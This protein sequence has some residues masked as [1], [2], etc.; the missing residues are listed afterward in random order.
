M[1]LLKLLFRLH[2]A[3]C[4]TLH[5]TAARDTAIQCLKSDDNDMSMVNIQVGKDILQNCLKHLSK[6][7]LAQAVAVKEADSWAVKAKDQYQALL[8][9]IIEE[10]VERYT[11]SSKEAIFLQTFLVECSREELEVAKD[12]DVGAHSHN[13]R[14]FTVADLTLSH[15]EGINT[16]ISSLP[17]DGLVDDYDAMESNG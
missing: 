13:S 17:E 8:E 1:S 10:E 16:V 15:I 14:S 5:L 2:L 11:I 9:M 3:L 4:L 12:F 7:A 6:K